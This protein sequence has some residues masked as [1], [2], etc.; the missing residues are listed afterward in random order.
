MD[1]FQ[2]PYPFVEGRCCTIASSLVLWANSLIWVQNATA[3]RP[4]S[5]RNNT[6]FS[7]DSQGASHASYCTD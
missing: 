1:L 3:L 4:K 7:G 6:F 5:A 2:L